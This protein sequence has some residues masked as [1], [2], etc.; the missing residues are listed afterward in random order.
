M[1]KENGQAIIRSVWQ[2]SA[3]ERAQLAADANIEL[4][5][6]GETT[7]PVSVGVTDEQPGKSAPA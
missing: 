7:P 5:V 6:W 3:V 2:P 1:L 4:I